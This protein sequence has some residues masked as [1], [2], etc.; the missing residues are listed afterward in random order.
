MTN[1]T[2][3][4]NTLLGCEPDDGLRVRQRPGGSG[5]G[6]EVFFRACGEVKA[7]NDNDALFVEVES[8]PKAG[9]RETGACLRLQLVL[10]AVARY[11]NTGGDWDELLRALRR[12]RAA[13]PWSFYTSPYHFLMSDLTADV[14]ADGTVLRIGYEH[15]FLKEGTT[16]GVLWSEDM[17]IEAANL[18][19][20]LKNFP[21]DENADVPVP[22]EEGMLHGQDQTGSAAKALGP[23]AGDH[24]QDTP[25]SGGAT[26]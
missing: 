13:F 12:V 3:T 6:V 5:I 9:P 8:W 1:T 15:Y 25:S 19:E 10:E 2:T 7:V 24:V 11:L 20:Y 14:A 22:V 18:H 21:S 4:D 16:E 26:F 23:V 17:F